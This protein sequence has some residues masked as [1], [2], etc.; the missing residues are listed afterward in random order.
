MRQRRHPIGWQLGIAHAMLTH[1]AAIPSRGDF[2]TFS[3]RCGH[4]VARSAF[5]DGYRALN[6]QG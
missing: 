5:I 1:D 4:A 6:R 3:V 2:A